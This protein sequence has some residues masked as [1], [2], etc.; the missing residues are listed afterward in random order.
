MRWPGDECWQSALLGILHSTR[1]DASERAAQRHGS[2][3]VE[4]KGP[5][6]GRSGVERARGRGRSARV[7]LTNSEPGRGFR[8][9]RA[10][11]AGPGFFDTL[12]NTGSSVYSCI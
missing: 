2:K 12:S 1:P 10:G 8:D 4:V 3:C 5:T 6:H 11:G 7:A 9:R